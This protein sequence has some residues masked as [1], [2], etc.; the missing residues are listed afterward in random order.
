MFVPVIDNDAY[1]MFDSPQTTGTPERRLL[2]AILERAILDFVGN[3]PNEVIEAE[4]WIFS[5]Q[6]SQYLTAFSF[7]WVCQQLDLDPRHISQIIRA[8][9]RRGSNRVA[10]WYF[11][12]HTTATKNSGIKNSSSKSDGLAAKKVATYSRIKKPPAKLHLAPPVHSSIKFNK[13]ILQ[14]F[15]IPT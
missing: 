12:K 13:S 4:H 3:E 11:T 6:D 14:D 15:S 9:P 8:M 7:N 2:L 1:S 5:E 10:P